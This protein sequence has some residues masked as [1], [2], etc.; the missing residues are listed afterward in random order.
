MARSLG[1]EVLAGLASVVALALFGTLVFRLPMTALPGPTDAAPTSIAPSGAAP[2][3][4]ASGS[5]SAPPSPGRTAA[6]WAAQATVLLGAEQRLAAVRDRL[7]AGMAE[8][9]PST[10]AIARELRS[11]NT[12]L[13][14]ALDAIASMESSGAPPALIDA[15]RAAHEAT[16]AISLETLQASVQNAP[17]YQ[18]GGTEV[19]ARLDEIATL[20]ARVRAEAGFP[21]AAP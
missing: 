13:T 21:S 11:M 12:T 14:G 5:S 10:T 9:P 6:P 3:L 7:A 19:V 16:L 17:A 8:V 20:A 2:S 1:P 15:L 18:A 4:I